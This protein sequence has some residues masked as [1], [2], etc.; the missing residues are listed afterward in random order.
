MGR[1]INMEKTDLSQDYQCYSRIVYLI[2]YFELGYFDSLEYALKSAY[3]F[4]SK[5]DRVYKYEN[6]ILKYLRIS[7]RIK[8]MSELD[9]MFKNMKRE[10][11][12]I[13]DD[14][15]EQNAFDAFNILYW[16]DSKVKKIP[17][18]ELIKK[19][20]KIVNSQ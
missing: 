8:T 9:E 11:E 14:P 15:L 13:K 17:M 5:R 1:I 2:S 7:F 10:L 20:K 18:M 16:L 12:E 19:S 4:M 3:H 6:I